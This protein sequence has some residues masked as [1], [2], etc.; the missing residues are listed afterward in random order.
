M[1]SAIRLT[2]NLMVSY[3]DTAVIRVVHR[4]LPTD[5]SVVPGSPRLTRPDHCDLQTW[6]LHDGDDVAMWL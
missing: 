2:L 6:Y 5:T 1:A 3:H 4:L